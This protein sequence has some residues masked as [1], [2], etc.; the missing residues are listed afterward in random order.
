M[1]RSLL[2]KLALLTLVFSVLTLGVFS[3][4]L[5]Q[6]DAENADTEEPSFVE[7]VAATPGDAEVTLSWDAATDDTEVTGYAVFY[8]TTSVVEA[9][10][11][12]P[13][14]EDPASV[15]YDNVVDLEAVL[16]YSLEDLTNDTTYYFAV[17][18][19]DA[20]GN[21]SLEYSSEVS[22]TPVAALGEDDGTPP[23]VVSAVA[24]ACNSVELTFSEQVEFP[25]LNAG[26]AFTI[27][28]FD[29]LE[30]LD[31]EDVM[32]SGAENTLTLTTSP[33]NEGA[34]YRLTVGSAIHDDFGNLM[35]SGTSDT[36]V[37]TGLEC[38]EGYLES[39]IEE[40]EVVEEPEE[41]EVDEDADIDAP[42][43]DA[44]QVLSNTELLLVFDEDVFFPDFEAMEAME[45]DGE[46]TEEEGEAM[47]DDGEAMEDDEDPTL[48]M[49][50]IFDSE[51]LVLE[52]MAAEKV[53]DDDEVIVLTT[54][55]HMENMEYFVSVT[56]LLDEAGNAT[57]GDFKS[58]ASYDT[59]PEVVEE[60][61]VED[62]SDLIA[63]EEVQNLASSVMDLLVNLS[64]ESSLDSA[65]DLVDQYLYVSMDGGET[66]EKTSEL[67]RDSTSF[68]FEGGVEGQA[69]LF[70][71]VSV[72]ENGNQSEGVVTTAALPITGP[73][74]GLLAAASLLGGSGIT[75]R[76]RKKKL[77]K[78]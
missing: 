50:A 17:V 2:A 48:A 7:N 62:A 52:V 12:L 76:R 60:V 11:N 67:G 77:G 35:V 13:E 24:S 71:V 58:S 3:P 61:V 75:G 1:N 72:D 19:I 26:E 22:A 5:A 33:M 4:A 59:T 25:E 43:L 73:G 64:W 34:Q 53:E 10:L 20:A 9:Y 23:T 14:G 18:A 66:Y 51:N 8:G 55:E 28:D 27:E 65:G 49:F 15:Q 41:E 74:L 31:V 6:D 69:Y 40:E 70:K 38:P 68:T 29:T 36:A 47:E 54:A 16:E 42:R 57:E 45:E 46:A 21:E 37:F 32:N 78:R 63:P 56:G 30:F 44:V 39:L